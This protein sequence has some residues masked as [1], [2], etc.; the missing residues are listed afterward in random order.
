MACSAAEPSVPA[1]AAV[2][3]NTVQV[4][5]PMP[6]ALFGEAGLAVHLAIVGLHALLVP[7]LATTLVELD[8]ARAGPS[9]GRARRRLARTLA[10]TARHTVIHP[11]VL[12]VLAGLAWNAPGLPLPAVAAE[13][14]TTLGQ[15]VVPLCLILI[16]CRSPTT[17][18]R[19]RRAR[20]R[21][22]AR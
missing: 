15:A 3:G 16:A 5:I 2:F 10:T 13:I 11:V 8:T 12:P 17:G 22:C 1:V 18:F 7:S 4:G 21:G 20:P 19:A 9:R 14:L 6:A